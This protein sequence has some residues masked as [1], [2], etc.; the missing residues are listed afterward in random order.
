MAKSSE[1]IL[2]GDIGAT[3]ARFAVIE[4]GM[5]GPATWMADADYPEFIDAAR[6]YVD[7]AG[8]PALDSALIAVAG[9]VENNRCRLTNRKWLIDGAELHDMLGLASA[10][11]INDFEATAWSLP[12]L[13]ANDLRAIGGGHPVPGAPLAVLGPGT[14]LGVSC[15]LPGAGGGSV[16]ASEGGHVTLP[17]TSLQE[18]LV[19]QHLRERF[20]HVSAELAISGQGLQNLYGAVAAVAGVDAPERDAHH[21]TAAGQDGSCPTSRAALDMFCAFL[22]GLAGDVAL[23]FGARG[24]IFVA[25]GIAPR[26]LDFLERSA[27]RARFQ[28]KGRVRA[29]VERIPTSVIVN[30]HATLIGLQTL[31]A[32]Q[33]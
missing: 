5:L 21:I 17:G 29:Y 16:I 14:G 30:P 23:T 8:R 20:G 13:G 15:Y 22:G 9:P 26:I 11:L 2:V 7:L 28:A 1:R 6:A 3:N 25:G 10:R 18:D 19:I 24:G 4:A 12:R 31:V 33:P 27:F 32:P